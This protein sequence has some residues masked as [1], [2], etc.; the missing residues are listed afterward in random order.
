MNYLM[1]ADHG[2][3]FVGDTNEVTGKGNFLG[4]VVLEAA[5]IASCKNGEGDDLLS[6]MGIDPSD[7]LPVGL[8]RPLNKEYITSIQL[9]S[10]KVNLVKAS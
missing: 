7:T 6:D 2:T 10:G 1:T 9:S 4:I 8:Y 3:F 5:S